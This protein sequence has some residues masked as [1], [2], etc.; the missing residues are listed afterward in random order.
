MSIFTPPTPKK[1]SRSEGAWG[2]QDLARW[3]TSRRASP[4]SPS[5][6]ARWRRLVIAAP[7]NI[8]DEMLETRPL[9]ARHCADGVPEVAE[10]R[11]PGR[12]QLPN[13]FGRLLSRVLV[14]TTGSLN[15][16]D[17]PPLQLGPIGFAL[18]K[19]PRQRCLRFLLRVLSTGLVCDGAYP[20]CTRSHF[21]RHRR[22]GRAAR[23]PPYP[24]GP[25]DTTQ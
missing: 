4:R 24:H 21:R 23:P 19:E 8:P 14:A 17:S 7:I 10:R 12:L 1:E 18:F 22:R 20:F 16:G 2:S 15:P 5:A 3:P 13:L 9:V 25:T 6:T 11:V